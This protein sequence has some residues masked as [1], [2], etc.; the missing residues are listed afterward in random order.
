M[1]RGQ[2]VAF[3]SIV[4]AAALV[5]LLALRSR[6]APLL[7]ADDAHAS[8]VSQTDCLSCHGPDGALPPGRNH[9]LRTD[10]LACHGRP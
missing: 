8:F 9:T 3:A 4:L 10:C 7:P 1:T 5:V 2:V 6:Q